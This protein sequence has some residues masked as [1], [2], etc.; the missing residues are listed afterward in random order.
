M[1]VYTTVWMHYN[2]NPH[3]ALGRLDILQGCRAFLKLL[4]D[5]ATALDPRYPRDERWNTP[6]GGV[7]DDPW[8]LGARL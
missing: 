5:I 4:L 8:A 2:N 6:S 7:R 1:T 3:G